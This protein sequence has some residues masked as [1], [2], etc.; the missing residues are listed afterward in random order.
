MSDENRVTRSGDADSS[1]DTE[2]EPQGSKKDQQGRYSRA[3]TRRLRLDATVS[4]ALRT[5]ERELTE[6][7]EELLTPYLEEGERLE[8]PTLFRAFERMI[9]DREE[10]LARSEEKRVLERN[11]DV[12]LR[13]DR[14]EAMA[15]VRR[16]MVGLRQKVTGTYG[17]EQGEA[18]LGLH[19]PTS[20]DPL[21]LQRQARGVLE[22][23]DDRPL[24]RP[25]FKGVTLD[26]TQWGNLLEPPV[27]RLEETL[28][29]LDHDTLESQT[30]DAH[31][32]R[33]L[34][35]HDHDVHWTARWL[36]AVFSLIGRE[37]VAHKMFPTSRARVRRAWRVAEQAVRDESQ[38]TVSRSRPSSSARGSSRSVSP[39]DGLWRIRWTQTISRRPSVRF[40][41]RAPPAPRRGCREGPAHAGARRPKRRSRAR[42]ER[43]RWEGPQRLGGHLV[44]RLFEPVSLGHGSQI[45]S[46][47]E[48][49]RP[50][51]RLTA[52]IDTH[53]AS[54]LG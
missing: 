7:L 30:A 22:R 39:R 23:L 3:V 51:S 27:E 1:R 44:P 5:H 45:L 38:S 29:Q 4:N 8:L 24:P 32:Q 10:Q 41:A 18:F 35:R 52:A 31:K 37:D 48:P 21:T 49:L 6:K 2:T 50:R 20:R 47:F 54:L 40:S 26:R 43:R 28:D 34:D 9:R 12:Q 15:E 25:R 17:K 16:L 13:I 36:V 14:R 42:R 46:R 53:A 33:D 11:Q 19:G